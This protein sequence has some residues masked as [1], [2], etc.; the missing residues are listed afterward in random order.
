MIAAGRKQALAGAARRGLKRFA[1]V[2]DAVLPTS[3]LVVLAYHRVGGEGTSQMDLPLDRFRDQM[4]RLADTARVLSLDQA[5]DEFAAERTG[6]DPA[7]ALTFD[8]GTADFAEHVVGVLDEF[9]LPATVY[10]ATEPVLTGERWPDGAAPLSAEA[11]TE[12]SGHRLVTIGCHTHAHLLLDRERPSGVAADLDRSIEVLTELTGSPPEHLP[13][14]RRWRLRF[15]TTPWCASGSS[16]LLWPGL[17]PTGWGEPTRI[18]WPGR[19]FN[20][21]TPHGTWPT[22]L[23]AAC[24]WRTTCAAWCS[25]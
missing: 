5:L 16:R 4:A 15:R 25:A 9:E 12:V 7:V 3:G 22:S 24:A 1:G 18:G 8:D 17:D 11:L 21:R 2:A 23:P 13:T 10:V 19:R 14:R 6:S 20:A